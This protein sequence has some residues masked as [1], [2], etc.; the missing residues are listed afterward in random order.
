MGVAVSDSIE[1]PYEKVESF[2][3]SGTSPQFGE[4]Y[5]AAIH[6]NAID[7]HVFYDNEGKLWMV[8]GS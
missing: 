6:P 1:G 2:L 8:Y 7:P 3:Y 5:N 4:A